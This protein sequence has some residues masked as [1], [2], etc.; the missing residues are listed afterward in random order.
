MGARGL[1]GGR[2]QE[3]GRDVGGGPRRKAECWTNTRTSGD[4]FK[5]V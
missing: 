3:A 1:T 2:E 4:T 5:T